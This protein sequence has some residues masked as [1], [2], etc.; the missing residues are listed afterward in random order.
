[1]YELFCN[2][3]AEQINVTLQSFGNYRKSL[4]PNNSTFIS[5]YKNY[6]MKEGK[7]SGCKLS[8]RLKSH[9]KKRKDK[10]ILGKDIFLKGEYLAL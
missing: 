2:I 9:I 5:K 7:R 3:I 10:K 1:M 8:Y 4:I 6:Y